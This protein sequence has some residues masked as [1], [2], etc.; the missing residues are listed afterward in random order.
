MPDRIARRPARDGFE[1][2]DLEGLIDVHMH[3]QLVAA[4]EGALAGK[5]GTRLL[6]DLTK[7]E[8]IS[9]LPFKVLAEARDRS[10]GFVLVGMQQ[11][12]RDVLELLGD[13]IGEFQ[14]AANERDGLAL[15]TK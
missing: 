14:E 13:D 10:A 15:L 1:R 11:G 7:C 8:H 12:V 2:L 3:E 4:L 6:L 9:M 5:K